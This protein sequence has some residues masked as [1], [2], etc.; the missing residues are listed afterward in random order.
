MERIRIITSGT[1]ALWDLMS[2]CQKMMP[3]LQ[4]LGHSSDGCE[5]YGLLDQFKPHVVLLEIVED[6]PSALI[7]IE[8]INSKF[9]GSSIVVIA[10]ELDVWQIQ[11]ALRSGAMAYLLWPIPVDRLTSAVQ[12]VHAGKMMLPAEA[13][14]LLFPT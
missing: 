11:T 1:S 7:V 9:A 12:L 13:L 8:T 6:F 5:L 10:H 14:T 2:E 3:Q 4:L